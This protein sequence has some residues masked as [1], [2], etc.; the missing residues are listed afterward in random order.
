MTYIPGYQKSLFEGSLAEKADT[1]Y[2]YLNSCELCPRKCRVN[3]LKG[4]L[5]YC[6]SEKDLKISSFNPHFGEESPLVGRNGSG[7]IFLSNCHLLCVFCQNYEISHLGQGDFYNPEEA[8]EIM[9]FLQEHG[10]HN[11]NLVSP[12][13]YAPQ[14]VKSLLIAAENNLHIPLIWNCSGY[15]NIEMLKILEG[16]V[17]IYM[18]DFKFSNNQSGK[19][20]C[21]APDYFEKA[22]ESIQEMF[23][24]VG[25]LKTDSRGIALEGLLVRHLI[26]P[27]D[28]AGSK[29]ILRFLSELSKE[30]YVNLMD[31]YRPVGDAYRFPE[32]NQYPDHS[33]LQKVKKMAAS[34]RLYRG[35]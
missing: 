14:L 29:K 17:D 13:H 3:R 33:D 11:I 1:L 5:G 12:S 6:K 28:I 26:M 24:Q 16:I 21:H 34:M 10:C 2:N 18:P 30:T 22:T 32:I 7:T 20:Y 4:E 8:A 23:R 25:D 35:F 27:N 31:Q 19:D 15:E 9:L